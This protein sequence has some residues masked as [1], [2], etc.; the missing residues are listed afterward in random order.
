MAVVVD[1]GGG[2][3]AVAS[4][5]GVWFWF[6]GPVGGRADGYAYSKDSFLVPGWEV[7]VVFTVLCGGVGGPELFGDPG[8]VFD[9]EDDA[10]VCY[11]A[12]DGGEGEDVEVVH[13]ILVAIV[14]EFDVCFAVVGG[15][16]VDFAFE[17]VG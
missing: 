10:V 4:W 9:A 15:V 14:V 2:V 6:E 16:D 1:E 7:E 8:D 11:G 12:A 5:D 17:D 13:V 3:D